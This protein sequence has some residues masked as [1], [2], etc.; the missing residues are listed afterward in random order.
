MSRLINKDCLEY[1]KGLP[2]N[3]ID[4]VVTS[5]PYNLDIKYNTHKDNLPYEEYSSSRQRCIE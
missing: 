4:L 2:D 3:C 1:M 5:P